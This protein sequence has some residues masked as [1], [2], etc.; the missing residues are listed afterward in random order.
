MIVKICQSEHTNHI[1]DTA[2][3]L[4]GSVLVFL[5][6]VAELLL[7]DAVSRA[8]PDLLFSRK[9]PPNGGCFYLDPTDIQSF[10]GR[11]R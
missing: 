1:S 10:I 7:S 3:V 2:L 11:L 6:R 4:T 9:Q 8:E 5:V